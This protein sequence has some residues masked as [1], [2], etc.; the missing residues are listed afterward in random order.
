MD[1]TTSTVQLL[2][3][4]FNGQILIPFVDAVTSAGF[5]EQTARNMMYKG[6]FPIPTVLNGSRRFVYIQDLAKFIDR[7]RDQSQPEKKI[8][9]GRPTKA[10]K[11][12][13]LGLH[14][15]GDSYA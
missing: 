4:R 14:N 10:S 9:R 5:Q 2:M 3:A 6:I 15:D 13:A 1:K 11:M 12:V 8:R 7:V